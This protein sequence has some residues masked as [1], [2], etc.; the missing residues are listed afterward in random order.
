MNG[1]INRTYTIQEAHLFLTSIKESR[2]QLLILSNMT[3]LK[4]KAPD[5][6]NE[7]VYAKKPKAKKPDNA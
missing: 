1:L 6:G 2:S 3:G 4:R 7:Q 5:Y